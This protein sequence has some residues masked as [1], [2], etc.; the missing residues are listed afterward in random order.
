MAG[1]DTTPEAAA[2]QDTT[3][4]N[5]GKTGRLRIAFE[6]SDLVRALAQAGIRKRNPEYTAE[7]VAA[8]LSRQL[9]GEKWPTAQAHVDLSLHSARNIQPLK[10]T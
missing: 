9:Y 6:L 10:A 2:I 3:Y 8:E 7:Q 5:L 4:R 1:F